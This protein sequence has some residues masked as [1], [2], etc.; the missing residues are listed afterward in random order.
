[1]S[2]LMLACQKDMLE[3]VKCLVENNAD[4]NEKATITGM[5]PFT[6]CRKENE[7]LL[8]LLLKYKVK[9]EKRALSAIKK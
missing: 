4:V 9:N 2:V 6:L 1:M 8:L 7:D 5:T 3:V